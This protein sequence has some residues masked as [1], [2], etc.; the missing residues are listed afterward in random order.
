MVRNPRV[1]FDQLFAGLGAGLSAEERNQRNAEGRS[2][3]D[4]IATSSARLRAALGPA[5]R[6]RFDEYLDN[7]RRL[8]AAF[9]ERLKNTPDGDTNLLENTLPL[10]GSPMGDPNLHNHKRV[11][12]FLAGHAGGAL[13]GG[14]HVKAPNGTPLSNA[15]L[16]VLHLLG[17]EDMKSFGDSEAA[18][19][20]S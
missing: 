3:L 16:S 20:L 19:S 11:P 2:I 7:V 12:F 17:C 14:V 13:K 18:L 8:I 5:D 4:W 9:L 1:V 6:R 15:M 10:Y